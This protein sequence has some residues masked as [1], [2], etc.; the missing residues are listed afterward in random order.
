[1]SEAQIATSVQTSPVEFSRTEQGR[2]IINIKS[3]VSA[4]EVIQ[5]YTTFNNE[6]SSPEI[7][8]NKETNSLDIGNNDLLIPEHFTP[9]FEI[10]GDV[11]MDELHGDDLDSAIMEELQHDNPPI[12]DESNDTEQQDVKHAPVEHKEEKLPVAQADSSIVTPI[13][14][15]NQSTKIKGG[16][17]PTKIA[18]AAPSP[19]AAQRTIEKLV[20]EGIG[21]RAKPQRN[22]K[23]RREV[24]PAEVTPPPVVH[25]S[26]RGKEL[27]ANALSDFR[28][29]GKDGVDFINTSSIAETKLGKLL[30]I[31]AHTCFHFLDAGEFHSVGAFWYFIASEYP[32]DSVRGLYGS[33]CRNARYNLVSRKVEGFNSLI[34]EATWAKVCSNPELR[35]YM[36]GNDL[37]YRCFFIQEGNQYPVRS[38]LEEWYMPILEEIA[39]TLKKIK[40]TENELL[41]PNF[42][43]LDRY[44]PRN[45]YTYGQNQKQRPRY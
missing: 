37:P 25:Y 42:S 6:E 28:G 16:D 20:K 24:V 17:R 35:S 1:M 29:S 3:D 36:L 10:I 43:F 2:L 19:L 33:A 38:N 44:D 27:L 18:T 22:Q 11:P 9:A 15:N 26:E 45:R 5:L 14:S 32:N 12:V 40:A 23:Q 31:N 34:A 13:R 30:D 8:F 4:E 39:S 7:T 41:V 21:S